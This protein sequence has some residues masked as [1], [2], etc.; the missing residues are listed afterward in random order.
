[1]DLIWL[2]VFF[3]FR[4]CRSYIFVVTATESL[5]INK[6]IGFVMEFLFR[7]SVTLLQVIAIQA[8]D[9]KG[10]FLSFHYIRYY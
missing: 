3:S 1:M 9:Y 5:D 8:N 4:L 10:G 7:T 6:L 2:G